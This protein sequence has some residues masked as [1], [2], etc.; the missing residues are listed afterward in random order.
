MSLIPESATLAAKRVLRRRVLARRAAWCAGQRE[1][2][3]AAVRERLL[4]LPEFRAAKGVHAFVSFP[5]EVDTEP[6]LAACAHAGKTIFLP[7]LTPDGK[8]IGCGRWDGRAPLLPG[9]FGT[10]E[11]PLESR[12]PVRPTAIDL[13]LVPGVAFDRRG[14]RLGYGKGYYDGFLAE[15]REQRGAMPPLV[16][17]AFS[18]QIVE[19]VPLSPWDV[20]IPQVLTERERIVTADVQPV[21]GSPSP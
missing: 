1:E 5:D 17:L 2:A 3:S 11:P 10:W 21:A 6:I 16:A 8:W 18:V 7:Y 4:A 19:A 20:R 9:P 14:G 13:V 15:L 12:A